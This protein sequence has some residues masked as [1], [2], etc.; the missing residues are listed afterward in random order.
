M[1]IKQLSRQKPLSEEI[2]AKIEVLPIDQL[3][4]LAIDLLDFTDGNDLA[5]S[6]RRYG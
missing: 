1:V 2:L 6:L 3:E 5:E 4:Q